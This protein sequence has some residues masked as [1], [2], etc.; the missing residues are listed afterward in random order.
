MS[1]ASNSRPASRA[2]SLQSKSRPASRAPSQQSR[3]R[4]ASR[5]PSLQSKG[6]P[7]RPSVASMG[8]AANFIKN[9][10]KGKKGDKLKPITEKDS[11]GSDMSEGSD[12]EELISRQRY[13]YEPPTDPQVAAN[14]SMMLKYLNDTDI[15]NVVSQLCYSLLN[16]PELPYNPYPGFVRRLRRHSEKFHMSMKDSKSIKELLENQ[17]YATS[18]P[19]VWGSKKSNRVWGLHDMVQAVDTKSLQ[20]FDWLI[21][22][23]TPDVSTV[24]NEE[25]YSV[26]VAISLV[27]PAVF[28]GTFY[29]DPPS[30]NVRVEYLIFG[31]DLNRAAQLFIEAIINDVNNT[32]LKQTPH[33]FLGMDVPGTNEKFP[34]TTI[35]DLWT[36]DMMDTRREDFEAALVSSIQKAKPITMECVFMLDQYKDIYKRGNKQYLFHFVDTKD[37]KAEEDLVASFGEFP[38]ITAREG[39]FCK[40]AHIEAYLSMYMIREE[41]IDFDNV[42]G[43]ENPSQ[44]IKPLP[45]PERST[46]SGRRKASSAI[47][48]RQSKDPKPGVRA[49]GPQQNAQ[50]KKVLTDGFKIKDNAY[51]PEGWK[52]TS[53]IRESFQRRIARMHPEADI[54]KT[55]HLM[56]L[57]FLMDKNSFGEE[58]AIELYKLLHSTAARL[59]NSMQ[60]NTV[61]QELIRKFESDNADSLFVQ[62]QFLNYRKKLLELFNNDLQECSSNHQII[63]KALKRKLDDLTERTE[64][65]VEILPVTLETNIKL[66]KVNFYCLCIFLH[67]V[68]D[69]LAVCPK[70]DG[71]IDAYMQTFPDELP[72]P[73]TRLLPIPPPEE[74]V[75]PKQP[76]PPEKFK[77]GVEELDIIQ[78]DR[79]FINIQNCIEAGDKPGIMAMEAVLMQYL[80]DTKVDLMYE[81]FLS[82]LLS[83][84][85]LPP[86]PYPRLISVFRHGGMKMD[87]WGESSDVLNK[88]LVPGGAK[89]MDSE[90]YIY[91]HSGCDVY[92]HDTALASIDVPNFQKVAVI[93]K[94]FVNKDFPQRKGQFKIAMVFAVSGFSPLYGAMVPYLDKL[95][96]HE[97]CYFK[98]PMG[99]HGEAIQIF[100]DI[101]REHIH[102]LTSDGTIVVMGLYV[103]DEARWSVDDV[104]KK[105]HS[106]EIEVANAIENKKPVYLKM[107]RPIGWRYLCVIKHLLLHY[108]ENA[109][110]DYRI[111]Y[112]ANPASLYQNILFSHEKAAF[113]FQQGGPEDRYNPYS[114]GNLKTTNI[115]IKG[116][117]EDAIH[118]QDYLSVFRWILTRSLINKQHCYL[119]DCW[120]MMHS[121][122]NQIEYLIAL[123]KSMQDLII[124]DLESD[125]VIA[126]AMK[127]RRNPPPPPPPNTKKK[128]VQ[129]RTVTP[130]PEEKAALKMSVLGR[131]ATAYRQKLDIVLKSGC[132][133]AP[134]ALPDYIKTKLKALTERDQETTELFLSVDYG[135][136]PVLEE[137][138]DLMGPLLQ[139]TAYDIYLACP[140]IQNL[141]T[142]IKAEVYERVALESSRSYDIHRPSY[143]E[144]SEPLDF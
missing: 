42:K 99:C 138:N 93:A 116:Q 27:G 67:L 53:P 30:V 69:A 23:L 48:G 25:H 24:Y 94:Q 106:L 14:I 133:F 115:Y 86:N 61:L 77:H 108:V 101:I 2:P 57:L 97:H 34:D 144:T 89:I 121:T 7:K 102:T 117:V 55:A 26:Q 6:G 131:M 22:D 143:D 137:I 124:Y 98:G 113:H 129:P 104:N 100:I 112:E 21:K 49:T 18:I 56:L 62:N 105:T 120:R 128:V 111:F 139:A 127:L 96:L 68:E 35:N 134:R 4:P 136:I 52:A 17:V 39:I 15:D 123:N 3:S 84:Q 19:H 88:K 87:L 63:H 80:I 40:K 140:D 74:G 71:L 41:R 66:R 47:D 31:P 43:Y 20:R 70:L 29:D 110:D 125:S 76:I 1:T 13:N 36:P 5:A 46:E 119:A 50:R 12:D 78:H 90:N 135:T 59:N 118:K 130:P 107:Y 32:V 126:A 72:R 103:G 92:G 8:M 141:V 60:L 9:L 51:L 85:H 58:F 11:D 28:F 142:A 33:V 38:Y 73:H 54:F 45:P 65:G 81:N 95:E 91:H 79:Q 10:R 109:E 16:R 64:S 114:G 122:A 83:E 37:G 75:P 82:A 132:S 44:V